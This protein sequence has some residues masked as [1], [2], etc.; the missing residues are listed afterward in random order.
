MA[1]PNK[2]PDSSAKSAPAAKAGATP[3]SGPAPKTGTAA[4]SGATAKS[5]GGT[6]AARN[7]RKAPEPNLEERMEGVQGWMAEIERRQGRM[8]YFGAAAALLAL[9]AAGVALFLAVTTKNDAVTKD[10]LA[11][12]RGQVDGLKQQITAT[13]QKQLKAT[14]ETLGSLDQRI[15]ALKAA[16]KRDAA[17]IADL[18]SQPAGGQKPGTTAQGG[19]TGGNTGTS[20][21]SNKSGP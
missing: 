4:K 9:V 8:T 6:A 17:D 16:Q 18:Q 13:T 21:N 2:K 15:E 3:K 14:S 11:Q 12:L 1:A 20:G 7:S 5:S 19:A 10:D